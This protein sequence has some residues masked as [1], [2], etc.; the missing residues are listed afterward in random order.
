[1]V[2]ETNTISSPEGATVVVVSFARPAGQR[3]IFR[4]SGFDHELGQLIYEGEQAAEADS[5][6]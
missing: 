2:W 5:K 1:M 4:G 6:R 3:E